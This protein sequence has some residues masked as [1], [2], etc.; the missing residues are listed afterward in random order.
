[1]LRREGSGL[2]GRRKRGNE[3]QTGRESER[4]RTG[5]VKSGRIA[6]GNNS[7]RREVRRKEEK[8]KDINDNQSKKICHE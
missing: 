8:T 4:E 2:R 5:G 3:R 6:G 1:M 7:N